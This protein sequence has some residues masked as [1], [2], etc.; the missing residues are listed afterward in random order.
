M[1]QPIGLAIQ[2]EAP[3]DEPTAFF[4]LRLGYALSEQYWGRRYATELVHAL[5]EKC[6]HSAG[7]IVSISG[8]VARDNLGSIKVLQKSGFVKSI[9]DSSVSDEENI[10]T[11]D[12]S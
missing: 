10:Y 4:E 6:R 3:F 7:R 9:N 1:P 11:L 2:Y 5:V 8:G 12:Q